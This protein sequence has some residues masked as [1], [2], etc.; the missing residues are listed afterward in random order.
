MLHC[1]IVLYVGEG[2]EREQCHLL[3]SCPVS[4]NFP[5]FLC[6]TGTLVA[7]SLVLNSRVGGFAYILGLCGSFK[8]TLLRYHQFLPPTQP[9]LILAARS[10]KGL[11]SQCWNR[12]QHGLAWCWDSL[13]LRY[14]SWFLSTTHK[15][16]IA[17]SASLCLTA[18]TSLPP[19]H[20]LSPP[21]PHLHTSYLPG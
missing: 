15:Y 4:S 12:G 18:A 14:P 8:Q 20:I 11:F 10:Y 21:A 3:S 19:H 13:P 9:L 5:Y 6:L 16:W 7:V 2:W 17:H 1:F